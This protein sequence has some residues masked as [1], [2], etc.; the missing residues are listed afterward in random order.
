M[1]FS[2]SLPIYKQITEYFYTSILNNK[3]SRDDRVPSVRE[4]AAL[5]EVNPN[6]AMRAFHELQEQHVIYNKRGVGY[7]LADDA[8]SIVTDIKRQEFVTEKLPV[9]IRDM[10]LLG[11]SF[12]EFK[13]LYEERRTTD[14]G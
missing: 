6:T 2:E 13:R 10:E 8:R 14:D 3:W 4:V 12:E 7:F 9:L 1:K 5:M 11:I